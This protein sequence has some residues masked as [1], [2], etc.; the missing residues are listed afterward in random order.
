MKKIKFEDTELHTWEERDRSM[1]EL[2]NKKTDETLVEWWDEDVREA[3]EDGF[4]DV[5]NLHESAYDYYINNFQREN[6]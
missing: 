6:R 4:L 2:R 5:N 3:F 1:I